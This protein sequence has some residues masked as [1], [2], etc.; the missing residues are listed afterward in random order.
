MKKSILFLFLTA[1]TFSVSAQYE[2]IKFNHEL[3]FADALSKAKSENKYVFIDCYTTWCGP[4]KL[5]VTDVFSQKKVGD[6][7]NQHF[8]NLK[9]DLEKPEN[10]FIAEKYEVTAFPTYLFFDPEEG[11]LKCKIISYIKAP[12][13][14]EM[15]KAALDK[16]NNFEIISKKIKGGDRSIST[17]KRFFVYEPRFKE[18]ESLVVDCFKKLSDEKKISEDA[19]D[20][21]NLYIKDPKSE[22]FQF[23]LKNRAKYA[24][25]Y[26]KGVVEKR[27]LWGFFLYTNDMDNAGFDSLKSVDPSLFDK[28]KNIINI[29]AAYWKCSKNKNDQVEWANLI[30]IASPY[31]DNQCD[32]GDYI[33]D[34]AWKIYQNSN[35]IKD[36]T[37]INKACEWAK[38][39]YTLQPKSTEIIDTYA[40]LLF[41]TGKKNDAI[42]LEE[43]ALKKAEEAAIEDR[44]KAYNEEL[45]NFKTGN[46]I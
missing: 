18:S 31:L 6:Y 42:K 2:G 27:I 19:W 14:I 35:K 43:E 38:K 4:C 24:S 1:F 12:I 44:V 39:A 36:K 7:Y 33:A 45:Q 32:D 21:F 37:I 17:V 11:M 28:A 10:K 40:H 26:G 46:K 30:S 20:L 34:K 5:M 22:P 8:I 29:A 16:D 13:F 15:A 25:K 3:T 41:A 23:F 9:L